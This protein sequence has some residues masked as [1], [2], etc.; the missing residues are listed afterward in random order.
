MKKLLGVVLLLCMAG[1]ARAAMQLNSLEVLVQQ[2]TDFT[3]TATYDPSAQ[4]QELTWTGGELA[5]VQWDNGAGVVL[6]E[7]NIELTAMFTNVA[8][9]SAGG[10]A[11]ANFGSGTFSL[12]LSN[13]G[14]NVVSMTGELADNGYDETET[15]LD[16]LTG[17]GRAKILTATFDNSMGFFD[18]GAGT[19]TVEWGGSLNPG[20]RSDLEVNIS[21]EPGTD[22]ASYD[23]NYVGPGSNSYGTAGNGSRLAII[24]DPAFIPEP[25]TLSMLGLGGLLAMRRRRA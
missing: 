2:I 21:L 3:F 19:A 14:V 4:T 1:S 17:M 7:A 6:G 12:I 18:G 22:F 23:L 24:A 15:S 25:I 8:D 5:A 11:S 20:N 9:F 16:Q 13:N 10:V